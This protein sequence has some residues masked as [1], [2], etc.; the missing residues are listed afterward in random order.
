MLAKL[1]SALSLSCTIFWSTLGTSPTVGDVR[2]TVPLD[3]DTTAMNSVTSV[4]GS[5]SLYDQNVALSY[6][7]TIAYED[8]TH[9]RIFRNLVSGS[10]IYSAQLSSTT[11]F[12][13]AVNDRIYTWFSYR[14]SL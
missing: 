5:V 11:P 9:V 1:R 3:I 12:T 14:I 13:W 4:M 2:Y 6:T 8:T 10:N 7:G